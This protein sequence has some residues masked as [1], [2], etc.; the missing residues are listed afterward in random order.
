MGKCLSCCEP[1]N[2]LTHN[3]H[4]GSHSPPKTSNT[5]MMSQ[6]VI[7][8]SSQP[9]SHPPTQHYNQ[10][11]PR[12]PPRPSSGEVVLAKPQ[13]NGDRSVYSNTCYGF[14]TWLSS[15]Q[16]P[17]EY[18]GVCLNSAENRVSND[19]FPPTARN[20]VFFAAGF[21]GQIAMAV[22]EHNTVLVTM[23]ASLDFVRPSLNSVAT[24]MYYAM[25]EEVSGW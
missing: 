5:V 22:P 15:N 23:G 9:Y 4:P 20:D 1:D 6:N 2:E 12:P 14:M 10:H 17:A 7:L 11:E 25:S 19:Y 8:S 18:P 16:D 13:T 21:G 24:Q 3:G